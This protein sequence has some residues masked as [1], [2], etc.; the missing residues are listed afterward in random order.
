MVQKYSP[1]QQDQDCEKSQQEK[2]QKMEPSP[3]Q[4]M[5]SKALQ[6]RYDI[7]LAQ[8]W[9][10]PGIYG[11][12]EGFQSHFLEDGANLLTAEELVSILQTQPVWVLVDHEDYPVG[13][14]WISELA[15]WDSLN[16]GGT[17]Q[18]HSMVSE[19]PIAGTA[20]LLIR[21]KFLKAFIKNNGLQTLLHLAFETLGIQKK[22][23]ASVMSSQNTAQRL[24]ARA[25]FKRCGVLKEETMYKGKWVD[26]LLYELRQKSWKRQCRKEI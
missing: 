8:I 4:K 5:S 14:Y 18:G 16:M 24:L 11:I 7:R 19:K 9:D 25:G 13:V 23:K 17:K 1:C 6:S 21:P 20:H 2:Y 15:Y 10:A 22:L 26:V 3:I 12:L